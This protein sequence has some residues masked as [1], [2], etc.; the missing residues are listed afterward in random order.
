MGS[1]ADQALVLY[2]QREINSGTRHIV[3]PMSH[4]NAASRAAIEA[5]RQ[6]CKLNGVE[7]S[8]ERS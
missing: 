6:L 5:V 7:L 4:A 2:V 8:I 1:D 3:I